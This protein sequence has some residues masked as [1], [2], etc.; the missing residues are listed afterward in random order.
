[1]KNQHLKNKFKKKNRE[2]F[3]YVGRK[4]LRRNKEILSELCTKMI[5]N[6]E[7][8]P[9]PKINIAW[10]QK[11]RQFLTVHLTT[12][13]QLASGSGDT[14]VL[15]ILGRKIKVCFREVKE[16]GCFLWPICRCPEALVSYRRY[17][18][19]GWIPSPWN[20]SFSPHMNCHVPLDPG[21]GISGER[22]D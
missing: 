14:H 2:I 5:S 17:L 6:Q 21:P 16:S 18:L 11:K 13:I 8:Y 7:Y 22:S 15:L 19:P 10:K 4:S 3:T 20:S 12:V 1:M 9:Q